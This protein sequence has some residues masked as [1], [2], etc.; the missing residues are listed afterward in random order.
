MKMT[1]TD[2]PLTTRHEFRISR[3]GSD[4]FENLVVEIAHGGRVGRGEVS[5]T[6]YHGET[7]DTAGR[8]LETWAPLIGDDPWERD[9]IAA[10]CRQALP[11][12]R[13]A[14]SGLEC[15]L[16]DLCAQEIGEPL[17]KL[18]GIDRTTM[19]LSS[20]SIG[21]C[22]WPAMERKLEEAS[23]FPVLKIKMGVEGDIDMLRRI[24]QRTDKRITVDANSGWTREL[25]ARRVAELA[26]LDVEMVEQPLVADDLEGF[27]QLRQ[28]SRIPIFADESIC[29]SA[30]VARFAGAID[31]VNVKLAKTGGIA[32]A[33]RVIATARAHGLAVMIGCMVESSLGITSAAHLA[34]LADH[35]DLDGHWLVAEDPYSG[36]G[37]GAGRLELPV[38]PGLG[39]APRKQGE[40]N[41]AAADPRGSMA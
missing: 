25:A 3:G 26:E 13:A 19:P 33:L 6:A 36:V 28:I 34:P 22:D 38:S 9:A 30:D 16:W 32:E 14:F 31:G 4:L 12:N 24:R 11:G 10:R 7:R 41:T 29:V 17:W 27:H 20:L 21:L 1:W 5:A 35:L 37:G 2:L 40:E 18:L 8:A 23:G 39:V 15:A